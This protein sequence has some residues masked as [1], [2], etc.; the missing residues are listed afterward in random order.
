MAPLSRATDPADSTVSTPVLVTETENA[1]L[2]LALGVNVL[3]IDAT[4]PED[5]PL[6]EPDQGWQIF[7][8]VIGPDDPELQGGLGVVDP[9]DEFRRG[10]PDDTGSVN[11]SDAVSVLNHLFGGA[12]RPS[13]W[14]AADVNGDGSVN[15]TDPVGL[16]NYLF[17]SGDTPPDPGPDDCGPDPDPDGSLGCEA[18]TN[19]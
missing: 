18:Y 5:L 9:P 6:Y 19:C 1:T 10:D 12:D 14:E 15:I 17:G 3:R 2:E 13:C 7:N 16:L 8:L 4:D 11:I